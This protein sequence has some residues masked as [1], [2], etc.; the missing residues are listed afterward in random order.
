[1]DHLFR[2]YRGRTIANGV[3][4]ADRC[5]SIKN[6]SREH[7]EPWIA[8][9]V[10]SQILVVRH[11]RGWVTSLWM[12]PSGKI[13]YAGPGEGGLGIHVE[14]TGDPYATRWERAPLRAVYSRVWG[15]DDDLVFASGGTPDEAWLSIY[16][17]S[18]WTEMTP[19]G[20][21]FAFHGVARD[22]IY[23]VGMNGLAAWWDGAQWNPQPTPTRG[24]LTSVHVVDETEVY[25]TGPCQ[26]VL[27]GSIHGWSERAG[28][29]YG[30]YDITK[31][32]GDVWVAAGQMGLGRLKDNSIEIVKPELRARRVVSGE[33]LII[34]TDDAILETKDLATFQEIRI[35]AM[36]VFMDQTEAPW[37]HR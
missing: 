15:L 32:N 23:A 4:L 21:V 37:I 34:V 2:E 11:F 20:N 36:R 28:V 29:T 1:M 9:V 17:G 14:R 25:A 16:D 24:S 5:E 27:V 30:L 3:L 22:L 18:R 7:N 26:R 8:R 6:W 12:S 35:D 33:G 13:Y 31:W 19:P 10:D